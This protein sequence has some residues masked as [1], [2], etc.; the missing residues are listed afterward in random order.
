MG[1]Y[2]LID[3]DALKEKLDMENSFQIYQLVGS[4][5]AKVFKK[6]DKVIFRGI[7]QTTYTIYELAEHATVCKGEPVY[8]VVCDSN[9]VVY[10][11]A[12]SQLQLV[13]D[14]RGFGYCQ[15]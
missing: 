11:F 14:S 8:R 5:A 2:E 4:C 12:E 6:G 9:N 10:A 15:C 7:P 13:A 3:M 1:N